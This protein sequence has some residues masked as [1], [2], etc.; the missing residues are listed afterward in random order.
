M[1]KLNV[2]NPKINKYE[3][4]EENIIALDEN[5]EIRKKNRD[6][7]KGL[8]MEGI[9]WPVEIQGGGR[10]WYQKKEFEL[11][12]PAGDVFASFAITSHELGHLRQGEADERFTV[13]EL[14]SPNPRELKESE[15]HNEIEKDAWGR[16]FERIKKYCPEELKLIENKFQ[17]FKKEGKFGE[18]DNFE[19][20]YKYI[21]KVSLKISKFNDE[22][23]DKEEISNKEKGRILGKM[24]KNGSLTNE[25]FTEQ[26]KWRTGEKIERNFAEN[27]IKKAAEKIAK[28]KY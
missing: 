1:E 9:K 4:P 27:F 20:F 22:F 14:G 2:E 13:E 10:S 21:T 7:Y 28:E 24:I 16:G 23:E 17:H 11:G 3:L 15:L 5:S 18:F 19:S 26:E 6:Y 8:E 25:F 12:Y